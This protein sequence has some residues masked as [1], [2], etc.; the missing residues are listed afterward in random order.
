MEKTLR[1]VCSNFRVSRRA[2]QGYENAGLV[3]P[4]GRNKKGHLLY[5][6]KAQ[7]RIEQIKTYQDMG[8]TIKEIAISIDG[9]RENLKQMLNQKVLKLLE[10][11]E[12]LENVIRLAEE[13][14]SRL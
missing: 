14:I 13:M 2:V 8:F 12:R 9:P 11:R 4:S 5:D 6:E 10:E 1:E 7:M 3:A